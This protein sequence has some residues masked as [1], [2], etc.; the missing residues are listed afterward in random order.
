MEALVTATG[1]ARLCH[2]DA[3]HELLAPVFVTAAA[4]VAMRLVTLRVDHLSRVP[5]HF[6]VV[7]P[8]AETDG[9]I[10]LPSDARELLAPVALPFQMVLAFVAFCVSLSHLQTTTCKFMFHAYDIYILF[11]FSFFSFEET[12]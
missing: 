11:F 1:G 12:P 4:A 6:P 2:P 3:G 5:D 8:V 9:T 7:I 10:E